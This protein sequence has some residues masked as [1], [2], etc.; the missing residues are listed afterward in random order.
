MPNSLAFI[1]RTALKMSMVCHVFFSAEV[2]FYQPWKN[3][4]TKNGERRSPTL[5]AFFRL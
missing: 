1:I 5:S 2:G 3:A 4:L